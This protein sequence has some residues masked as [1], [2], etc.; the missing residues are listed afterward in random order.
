M[1]REPPIYIRRI[2]TNIQW[3]GLRENLQESPIFD[4]FRWRYKVGYL[5]SRVYKEY[6]KTN[7]LKHVSSGMKRGSPPGILLGLDRCQNFHKGGLCHLSDSQQRGPVYRRS[8]GH[9]FFFC[10]GTNKCDHKR[11]GF[12]LMSSNGIYYVYIYISNYMRIW[13]I[14]PWIE[15]MELGKSEKPTWGMHK[16]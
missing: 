5:G 12:I 10:G 3:I 16:K 8:P 13:H 6:K 1:S 9:R 2:C 15:A 14:V 11:C 4:G 7:P